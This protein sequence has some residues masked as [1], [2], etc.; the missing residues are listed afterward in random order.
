MINKDKGE[1]TYPDHLIDPL[2][3]GR[4]WCLAYAKA[5]WKDY[6]QHGEHSFHNNRGGYVKIK[7]YAQGNQSINKYKNLMN[8]SDADNDT[9]LAIDWSV[10]P[11]VPKF[12]RIALGKLSKTEY[13]ISVTPIDGLAQSQKEDYFNK[14]KAKM[15]L[16]NMASQQMPGIEKMRVTNQRM[17]KS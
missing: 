11:V 7:D 10:L 3:K 16:R 5:A 13:N 1:S 17:M 14:L 9:W 8:V 4:D 15:D 6:N 2:Q 12:R